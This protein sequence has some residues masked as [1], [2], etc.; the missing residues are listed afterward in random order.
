MKIRPYAKED[1]DSVKCIYNLSKPD[2]CRGS[3]DLRAIIPLEDDE[4]NLKLFRESNILVV[5]EN[6][7]LIGFAGN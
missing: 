5:E 2:E 3:V 1:W 7:K 4:K 6:Y